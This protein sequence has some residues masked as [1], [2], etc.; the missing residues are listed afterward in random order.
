M[1]AVGPTQTRI[2]WEFAGCYI[3]ALP[4]SQRSLISALGDL[5]GGRERKIAQ[6]SP[7]VP[8]EA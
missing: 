5:V 3:Q 1:L 2:Y 7:N 8:L 6:E 4:I